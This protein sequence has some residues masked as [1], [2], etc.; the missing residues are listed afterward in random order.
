M[1]TT[2]S[3]LSVTSL[4]ASDAGTY[5]CNPTYGA[6]SLS[7]GEANL[8]VL[9]KLMNYELSNELKGECTGSTWV[10][11]SLLGGLIPGCGLD[12]GLPD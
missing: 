1:T 11:L 5:V 9:S 6:Y 12:F 7:G 3:K 2:T 8:T 10:V 4:K